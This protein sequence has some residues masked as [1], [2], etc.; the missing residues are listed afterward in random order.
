MPANLRRRRQVLATMSAVLR[1]EEQ[2]VATTVGEYAALL[3]I[4]MGKYQ[5]LNE[6]F[7]EYLQAMR[8]S[9]SESHIDPA[10]RTRKQLFLNRLQSVI[11][12]QQRENNSIEQRLVQ[13][14][15]LWIE[16]RHRAESMNDRLEDVTRQ[17]QQEKNRRQQSHDEEETMQ[18]HCYR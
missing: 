7:A 14:R 1:S 10:E 11:E 17:E 13:V 18:R 6:Y 15:E 8:G 16:A 4:G 5:K 9:Q 12:Q 2:A 3:D